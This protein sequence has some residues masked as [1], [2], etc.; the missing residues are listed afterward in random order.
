MAFIEFV[1]TRN[2]RGRVCNPLNSTMALHKG[3]KTTSGA[4]KY[5]LSIRIS[6]SVCKTM[7]WQLGDR[8]SVAADENDPLMILLKR[9]RDGGWALS[10]AGGKNSERNGLRVQM[11]APL[12]SPLKPGEIYSCSEFKEEAG[13]VVFLFALRE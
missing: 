8:V 9:V 7:R 11:T 13:G 3:G 10:V 5:Q 1:K 12:N 4:D 2:S 6:G